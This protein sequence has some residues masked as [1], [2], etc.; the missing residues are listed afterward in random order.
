MTCQV[1]VDMVLE[2]ETETRSKQGHLSVQGPLRVELLSRGIKS[3][4]LKECGPAGGNAEVL[5]YGSRKQLVKWLTEN[6]YELCCHPITTYY[7]WPG[8]AKP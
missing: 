4:I 5:L 6:K 2:T 8:A 3:R 7:A 1:K